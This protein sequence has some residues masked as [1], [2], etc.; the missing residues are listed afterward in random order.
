MLYDIFDNGKIQVKSIDH[1]VDAPPQYL[2]EGA[3]NQEGFEI[4]MAHLAHIIA[5]MIDYYKSDLNGPESVENI[6]VDMFSVITK[7]QPE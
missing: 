7:A 5:G 6:L 4:L 1:E 2:F 3:L